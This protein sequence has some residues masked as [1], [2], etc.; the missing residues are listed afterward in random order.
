MAQSSKSPRRVLQ[1]AYQVGQKALA[2][3]AH[4]Y[5]PKKFTQAQLFACLVLKEFCQR[6]YRGIVALLQ[7]LPEL[8]RSIDLLVVPHFTTLQKAA[9]RLLQIKLV[10]RL[11]AATLHQARR[12]KISRRRLRLAALD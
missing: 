6:D 8:C 11:L 2:P 7:D 3:Y 12:A 5:S 1:V 4:R 9:Q 10:R